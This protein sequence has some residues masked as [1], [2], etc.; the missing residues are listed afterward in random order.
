MGLI[1]AVLGLP[2]LYVAARVAYR[3]LRASRLKRPVAFELPAIPDASAI[4]SDSVPDL[5]VQMAGRDRDTD[6]FVQLVNESSMVFLKGDSGTGKST[7]L[8]LG[9]GA[10]SVQFRTVAAGLRRFVALRLGVWPLDDAV[11]RPFSRLN[12]TIR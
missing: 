11:R 3:A 5:N 10:R 1:A 6:D 12:E 7:F 8:K 9:L 2:T 4:Y